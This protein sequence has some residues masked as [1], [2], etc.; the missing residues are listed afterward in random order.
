MEEGGPA[1]APALSPRGTRGRRGGRG[2]A[3][4]PRKRFA[5]VLQWHA[6]IA[7]LPQGADVARERVPLPAGSGRPAPLQDTVSGAAAAPAEAAAAPSSVRRTTLQARTRSVCHARVYAAVSVREK[8]RDTELLQGH[9]HSNKSGESC[10]YS[11]FSLNC[12]FFVVFM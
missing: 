1:P 11:H 4:E 2:A 10:Y 12:F 9:L 7:Q 3:V 8:E 5:P 6:P